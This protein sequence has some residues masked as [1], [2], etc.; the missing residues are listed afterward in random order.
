ME[1]D[2]RL[3]MRARRADIGFG[4]EKIDLYAFQ[5][6]SRGGSAAEKL[7]FV[8]QEPQFRLEPFIEIESQEAQVLMDD[9]WEA[10]IRPT[11]A[12]GSAGAMKAVQGHLA[13]MR[14][15]VF[16]KLGIAE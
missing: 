4:R 12:R 8:K 9:L 2:N 16:K 10:G 13:D 11:E 6:D 1:I 15:I 5:K 7:V 3:K 14:K